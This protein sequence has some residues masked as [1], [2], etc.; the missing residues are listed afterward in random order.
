ME[1]IVSKFKGKLVKMIK[2]ANGKFDDYSMSPKVRQILLYWGYDLT[3]KM[4]LL[5]QQKR[6]ITKSKR[7]LF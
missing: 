1:N 5:I 4:L 3:K 6:S 2:V 7:K